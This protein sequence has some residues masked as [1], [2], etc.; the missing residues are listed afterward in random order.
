ME[1]AFA[2]FIPIF[3]LG[4]IRSFGLCPPVGCSWTYSIADSALGW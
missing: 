3:D 2:Y 4:D 1:R